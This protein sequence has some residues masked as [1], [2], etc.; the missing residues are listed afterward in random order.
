[1]LALLLAA[2]CVTALWHMDLP[3]SVAPP[4]PLTTATGGTADP[5]P[6]ILFDEA[7]HQQRAD[8]FFDRVTG[9]WGP[10]MV[11]ATGTLFFLGIAAARL[12]RSV[13][14]AAVI[15]VR[16]RQLERP[17]GWMR[18]PDVIPFGQIR[19]V[20]HDRADRFP[21]DIWQNLTQAVALGAHFGLKWGQRRRHLLRII[22][23][24]PDG[25][26]QTLT[27]ADNSV[28][29]GAPQLARFAAYLQAMVTGAASVPADRKGSP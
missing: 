15:A 23:N 6:A 7:V 5:T 24:A 29:G 19:S 20:V 21:E 17:G 3:A 8:S 26:R 12:V 1:M 11:L 22:W 2:L 9:G 25:T 28:D 27:I 16:A 13:R 10:V 18:P 14:P 4:P